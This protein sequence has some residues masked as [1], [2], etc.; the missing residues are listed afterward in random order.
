M[1]DSIIEIHQTFHG[2]SRGHRLL[3]SSIELSNKSKQLL[4]YLTDLS[5]P[6]II[7]GF[8]E[9]IVGYPL[10]Y[11]NYYALTKTW[12]A[13]EMPRPG[14]VWSHTLLFKKNDLMQIKDIAFI[15]RIFK[16]ITNDEKFETYRE[17]LH[18]DLQT[19]IFNSTYLNDLDAK[20]LYLLFN[21]VYSEERKPIFIPSKNSIV[22][23][24]TLLSFWNTQYYSLKINFLFS[25]GSINSRMIENRVFDLQVIP[26]NQEIKIS[27][28]YDGIFIRDE[29]LNSE[30]EKYHK[31]FNLFTEGIL[32]KNDFKL[33]LTKVVQ[34]SILDRKYFKDLI[35]L[36]YL[37]EHLA[38][39]YTDYTIEMLITQLVKIFPTKEDGFIIKK[40]LLGF[41]KNS[42]NNSINEIYLILALL[43]TDKYKSLEKKDLELRERSSILWKD[44]NGSFSLLLNLLNNEV[45]EYFDEYILGISDVIKLNQLLELKNI[46]F[47]IYLLII[48]NRPQF[49]VNNEVWD[50]ENEK[51]KELF[52]VVES[53]INLTD[54][55]NFEIFNTIIYNHIHI[56]PNKLISV[57]PQVAIFSFLN[58]VCEKGSYLKNN[59]NKY[60]EF[61]NN[62]IDW[63]IGLRTNQQIVLAWIIKNYSKSI[64]LSSYIIKYI[65]PKIISSNKD[66]SLS[67]LINNKSFNLDLFASID[68]WSI[69]FATCLASNNYDEV[70]KLLPQSFEKIHDALANE[71]MPYSSWL[72]LEEFV[73]DIG[74]NNWDKCER[75]RLA[76]VA[77]ILQLTLP[78]E[79]LIISIN[80][81]E[82][83]KRVLKILKKS[84]KGKTYLKKIKLDLVNHEDLKDFQKK[85]IFD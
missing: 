74:R 44:R 66:F 39:D 16:R 22:F 83:F 13:Y 1:N 49:A 64:F 37:V 2:Y 17:K 9:Y 70:N 48:Y 71:R 77:K 54:N 43:T 5:G 63:E 41:N 6:S 30:I 67:V 3:A 50:I 25:T 42:F 82:L 56:S 14:C 55:I 62:F 79:T 69:V 27:H 58:F 59:Y 45:N 78:S 85:M 7:N 28:Q 32:N 20:L 81:K 80:N 11:E 76:F 19:E 52:D 34:D 24:D 38:L 75:V 26:F 4:L 73:P 23:E 57:N 36:Y 15:K 31:W 68:F 60:N 33:F 21:K 40:N 47:Q 51:Q 46:R 10:E 18:I 65:S 84:E 29:S 72:M 61:E 35:E 53:S 12:Y 8:D